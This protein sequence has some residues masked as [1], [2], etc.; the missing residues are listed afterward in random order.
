MDKEITHRFIE[1][2]KRFVHDKERISNFPPKAI[3]MYEKFAEGRCFCGKKI[4]V[5]NL[6]KTGGGT[7]WIFQCGHKL[8]VIG[9]GEVGQSSVPGDRFYRS[10]LAVVKQSE[11]KA[12]ASGERPKKEESELAV[13]KLLCH[14]YKKHLHKFILPETDSHIDVIGEDS[15]GTK[16]YFQVTQLYDST[17]WHQLGKGGESSIVLRERA[18]AL[19]IDAINRKM[20]YPQELRNEL[21]LVIDSGVGIQQPDITIDKIEILKRKELFK[22]IWLVGRM[23]NFTLRLYP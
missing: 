15:D 11:V 19:I 4:F 14:M 21:I 18:T 10:E 23:K 1:M 8:T 12:Q 5:S 9:L 22:E 13:V 3:E 2:N 16:E 6:I 7:D 17:F 20:T